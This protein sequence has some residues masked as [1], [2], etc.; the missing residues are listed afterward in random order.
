MLK[1][2]YSLVALAVGAALVPA[3]AEEAQTDVAKELE[4]IVVSGSRIEKP[5]K[6]VAGSISVTTQDELEKQVVT[7]MNQLFRYDPSIQVTGSVGGAQNFIVRGMG[8]NRVLMIKDGM[9][10][11]EGYG[12]NGLNDIV[13]RGFIDTDTLKRVE[14]AKGASSS[15]YGS[16]ALGGIVVF[17]TKDASDYLQADEK[18][19]GKIRFSYSDI[20]E[21]SSIG[22]TLAA[23]TGSVEHLIS[24]TA[25]RG[26]E[27]QNYYSTRE[28][29][30]IDSESLLYK[31]KF[32]I[33]STDSLTFTADIWNQEST[34]DRADGLLAYFR[35]LAQFGYNIVEESL[36]SEKEVQSFK[37]NY[38]SE[39]SR[40]LYDY[41]DVSIYSNTSKQTDTEYGFLD[42]NAPMFGTVQKRHMWRTGVF[43]QETIGFLSSAA[44]KLNDTHTLGFGVDVESTD[45]QRTEHAYRVAEGVDTPLMDTE[46][47]KF[48]KNETL[49]YGAY[50]ND[51][52]SLLDGKLDI[53]PGMRFDRYEMDPN[54]ALKTDGTTFN[55]IK[56]D[57]LSLNFGA[58]Y[59]INPELS[60]YA[61]YGQG[62]KVPAY[63][64]AYIEHDN[65]PT[66]TYRY[67]IVPNEDLA[68]EESDTYEVGLRGHLG[69]VAFTTALFY[70][71]FDNFLETQLINST[72]VTDANGVFQ[73]MHDTFHYHNIDAVTIKGAELSL[74]YFATD[75]L[76]VF[77]RASYQH[78][79]NDMTGDYL[80]TISPLSGVV[81]VSYQGNNWS[82]DLVTSWAAR[83]TKVNE[84][85]AVTPGYATMDWLFNYDF[86][87]A[88]KLNLAV[89]NLADRKYLSA[90]SVAGHAE[91]DDVT[92][93]MQPGRTFNVS[94]SYQF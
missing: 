20:S 94:L 23:I 90:N 50:L 83:M 56:E 73:Y 5:L 47:N 35:G 86:T 4:V 62:F 10:M 9:R 22:G 39:A 87:E 44:K 72:R 25:R 8:S 52:I 68:P 13:G 18:L 69:S 43:K 19:A 93:L 32:N 61:Q 6:D 49:R 33:N 81:G 71:K 24:A 21:Q 31:A 63:D 78:G 29:F 51:T 11:N 82:S 54:G 92:S 60:V 91:T 40:A 41:L 37:L 89:Y 2:I 34:G 30:D 3:V 28:P 66:S 27:Q 17:T 85:S 58:I 16:D 12:A 26:E 64:L 15:L 76:S 55:S 53:V 70:N 67:T 80:T 1:P 75:A 45:S 38:R 59:Y 46:T 88:F 7:D 84:G 48:P 57:K 79:K 42:I 36:T 14:V 65:Q 74:T 77:G